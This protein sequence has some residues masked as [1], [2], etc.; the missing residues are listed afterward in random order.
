[1]NIIIK[2]DPAKVDI[3]IKMP[4]PQSKTELA[5]FLGMCNYLGPYIPCLS[6]VTGTLRQLK[7]ESSQIQVEPDL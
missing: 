5:S 4:T 7:Q 1:M 6:D 2:P 3:I